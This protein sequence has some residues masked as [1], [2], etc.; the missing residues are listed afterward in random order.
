MSRLRAKPLQTDLFV[1]LPSGAGVP[2]DA[3]GRVVAVS[4]LAL[5]KKAVYGY[6][7]RGLR[8]SM[9]LVDT[10]GGVDTPVMKVAYGYDDASRLV[11]VQKDAD[12]AGGRGG[13]RLRATWRSAGTNHDV[14]QTCAPR[15]L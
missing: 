7:A 8:T 9:D 5:S 11:T 14:A 12:P 13:L 15:F 2:L 10:T 4:D 1:S 6:D 3:F